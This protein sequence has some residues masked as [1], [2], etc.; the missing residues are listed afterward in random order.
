MMWKMPASR[1]RSLASLERKSRLPVTIAAAIAPSSPPMIAL[2]RSARRLRALIDRR[3]EALAPRS[4]R[5]AA[6][7]SRDRAERRADRADAGEKRV[8]REIVAAGQRRAR[9]RQQARLE[10]DV[11]AG[12]DVGRLARRHPHPA[13][14][15]L[16]AACR[17]RPTTA[18]HQPRAD[19][20]Q[21]DLLDEALQRDDAD[22]VEHRRGDP[23]RA[24][25]HRQEA[26]E[27]RR[28]RRA[29]RRARTAARARATRAPR[30]RRQQ[31]RQPE[32]RLAVGRQIERDAAHRRDRNPEEKA[33]LLDLA[34]ERASRTRRASPA[35]T[36]RRA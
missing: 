15:V 20:P 19:G 25:P 27:Q 31:R 13:R 36:R 17:R 9:G 22:M 4:P 10:R 26:R 1:I 3:A 24:Q 11:I 6:A 12:G 33:P 2:T 8:A 14:R 34:R 7:A 16:G 32:H 30:K 29:R 5:A 35:P 23:R 18:D 28:E 21:V